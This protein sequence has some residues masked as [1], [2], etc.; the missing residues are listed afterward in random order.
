[1]YRDVENS[2]GE[3]GKENNQQ[4]AKEEQRKATSTQQEGKHKKKKEEGTLWCHDLEP[5]QRRY[6]RVKM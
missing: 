4:I 6:N 5:L 1:M 3:I 2:L